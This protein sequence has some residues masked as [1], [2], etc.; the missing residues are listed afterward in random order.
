M[1]LPYLTQMVLVALVLGALVLYASLARKPAFQKEILKKSDEATRMHLDTHGMRRK[2]FM[3][4]LTL[5]LGV[6]I[7][8]YVTLAVICFIRF[9]AEVE[10]HIRGDQ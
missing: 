9:C 2:R 6:I 4:A 5:V 7:A 1:Q 8:P 3:G 10:R